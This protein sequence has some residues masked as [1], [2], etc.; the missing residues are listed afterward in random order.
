MTPLARNRLFGLLLAATIFVADQAVKAWVIGPLALRQVR[1]IEVLPFFDLTYVENRGISL[2]LFSATS[3]EMRWILVAVTALIAIVVVA[4]MLRE[5][6]LGDILGLAL[7]LGGALGNIVDRYQL[8]YVIDYADLHIGE[9]RPFL[10]YNIADACITVGVVIILVR[11]LFF[12]EK[13]AEPATGA[14]T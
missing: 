14:T 6:L 1:N 9:F 10:V 4:W 3:M 5:R 11:S 8:G 7:I 2:G 13:D 12:A